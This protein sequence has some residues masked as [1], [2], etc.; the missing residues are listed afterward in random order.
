MHRR[1]GVKSSGSAA[2]GDR[3]GDARL[4]TLEGESVDNAGHL[5]TRSGANLWLV[6]SVASGFSG[7]AD[8]RRL[9]LLIQSR[10]PSAADTIQLT[11]HR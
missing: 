6:G 10:L 4:P 3:D 7:D 1:F 9:S 11:R 8:R 2:I 5:S